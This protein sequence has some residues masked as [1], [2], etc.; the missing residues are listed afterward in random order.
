[1]LF[2]RVHSFAN[3]L[4]STSTHSIETAGTSVAVDNT[5]CLAVKTAASATTA[6]CTYTASP[7]TPCTYTTMTAACGAVKT[8]ASATTAACTYAA[9]D[10]SGLKCAACAAGKSLTNAGLA[11]AVQTATSCTTPAAA[12]AAAVAASFA[13][14]AL[15]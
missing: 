3:A 6:A 4:H 11:D 1:M 14:A 2:V 13:A 8:A 7:T 12:A 5:D 10:T 9:A 15:M